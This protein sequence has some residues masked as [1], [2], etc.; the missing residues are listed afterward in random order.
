MVVGSHSTSRAAW[1]DLQNGD[2]E[3]TIL[4]YEL[5]VLLTPQLEAAYRRHPHRSGRAMPCSYCA[6]ASRS[7]SHVRLQRC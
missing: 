6:L 7:R 5:S 1:G 3:L 4:S 2:S